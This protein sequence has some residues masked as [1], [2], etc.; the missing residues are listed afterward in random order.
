MTNSKAGW[1]YISRK[2]NSDSPKAYL[3]IIIISL[4]VYSLLCEIGMKNIVAG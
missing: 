2:K 4:S 1:R 3:T